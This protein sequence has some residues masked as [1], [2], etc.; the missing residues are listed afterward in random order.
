MPKLLIKD[1][2]ENENFESAFLVNQKS[3]LTSKTNRPYLSIKLSDKS[4]EIEARVWDNAES[5]GKLFDKHDFIKVAGRPVVFQDKVQLNIIKVQR[6]DPE[7]VDIQD[8][9]PISKRNIEEMMQELL[10]LIRSEIKNSWIQKFLLSIFEDPAIAPRVKRAPAAKTNHH[11]WVGGLLEHIVHLCELARDVL[12]H[13]PQVNSDLVFTGLMLHDIGK[14]YEL[15]YERSFGYTDE[16]QLVGHL[17]QGVEMIYEKIRGIPDFPDKLKTHV[18]HIV[19]A[20]HGRLEFGSP[21]LPMTLEA[22]MVHYLDDMDSKIQGVVDLG[23]KDGNAESAWTPFN[24]LFG[25][26]M[27]KNSNPD[28]DEK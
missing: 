11:A 5:I 17:I 14:I 13:Y 16:G 20:H 18:V 25:R 15:S 9:L 27:Y 24:R 23:E 6:L 3:L 8:F 1:L 2:K 21:K 10:Q 7:Q 19:L 12:K 28:L 4:G 26:P 22:I